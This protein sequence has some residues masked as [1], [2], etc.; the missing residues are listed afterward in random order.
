MNYD[1]EPFLSTSLL[2]KWIMS[3]MERTKEKTQYGMKEEVDKA[4]E[5]VK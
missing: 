4:K 5:M 1:V 3:Y 2:G